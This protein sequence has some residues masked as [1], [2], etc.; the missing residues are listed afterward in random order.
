MSD[1]IVTCP[2]CSRSIYGHKTECPHCGVPLVSGERDGEPIRPAR[3]AVLSLRGLLLV[4]ISVSVLVVA[5]V[6][7]FSRARTGGGCGQGTSQCTYFAFRD[8][9]EWMLLAVPAALL[10]GALGI[11][12]LLTAFPDEPPGSKKGVGQLR[13]PNP[14]DPW[15]DLAA[16]VAA[17]ASDDEPPGSDDQP[18][19]QAEILL[20]DAQDRRQVAEDD[21]ALRRRL[22][23]DSDWIESKIERI[24]REILLYQ[25]RVAD[26]AG[27][28]P[29]E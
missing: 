27:L 25:G 29:T 6:I 21:L 15:L 8:G 12:D 10:A 19:T 2:A 5:A 4:I 23:L 20:A 11:M 26:E 3:R 18:K 13:L 9:D 14:R 24:D 28:P 16:K 7:V 22:D 1:Q 17:D